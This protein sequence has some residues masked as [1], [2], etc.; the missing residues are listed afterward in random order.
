VRYLKNI[1]GEFFLKLLSGSSL[2][3]GN[4]SVG[5]RECSAMGV[6]VI[7]IGSRQSGRERASNVIDVEDYDENLH[8]IIKTTLD[9]PRPSPSNL[10]G[11]G[12]AGIKINQ[13]LQNLEF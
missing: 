7:N 1:Q 5:I 12:D 8:S 3:I 2:L 4:S 6:R 11:A 9:L 10:Y 13:T